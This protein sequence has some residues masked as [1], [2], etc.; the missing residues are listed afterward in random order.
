M[1]ERVLV[2]AP[3]AM[4]IRRRGPGDV[5]GMYLSDAV[6]DQALALVDE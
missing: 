2:P 1:R 6:L 5:T 3:V 4:E